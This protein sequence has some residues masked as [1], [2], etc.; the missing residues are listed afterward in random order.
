MCDVVTMHW[1]GLNNP[2]G[3]EQENHRFSR[4]DRE[5]NMEINH[6][7]HVTNKHNEQGTVF[8][9]IPFWQILTLPRATPGSGFSDPSGTP[10]ASKAS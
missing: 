7:N 10:T 5:E 9:L 6:P 2:N 3:E 8:P 1:N 4:E